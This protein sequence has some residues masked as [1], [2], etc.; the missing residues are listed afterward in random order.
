GGF[1]GPAVNANE[2]ISVQLDGS[3]HITSID[4]ATVSGI[5][6]VALDAGAGTDTLDYTGNTQSVTVNL[7][8]GTA[9]GFSAIPPA[10]PTAIAGVDNVTGGSNADTLTGDSNANVL[11]GGGGN[12][13]LTGGGGSDTLYGGT[14]S[15]DSGNADIG[16]FADNLS[17]YTVTFD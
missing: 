13:T 5:E 10:V 17:T 15:A 2:T 3:N 4:T 7:A 14:A 16:G 1:T 9:T 6:A 12:D 11:I 8:N